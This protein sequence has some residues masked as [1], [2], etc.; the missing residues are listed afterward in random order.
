METIQI[1]VLAVSCVVLL[2]FLS[3]VV[4]Y[5]SLV[6]IELRVHGLTLQDIIRVVRMWRDGIELQQEI[7]QGLSPA[8]CHPE[9]V[10]QE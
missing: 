5:I 6:M 1:V 10:K 4:L 7:E 9:D 8:D 3:A 2:I